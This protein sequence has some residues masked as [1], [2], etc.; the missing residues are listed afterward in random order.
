M[1]NPRDI[2]GKR[3]RRRRRRRYSD[4]NDSQCLKTFRCAVPTAV[5]VSGPWAGLLF[6]GGCLTFR[7][8]AGV[9]LRRICSEYCTCCHTAIEVLDQ[10]CCLTQ[11]KYNDTGSASPSADPITPGAGIMESDERRAAIV[12]SPTVT[13]RCVLDLMGTMNVDDGNW[14]VGYL[15]HRRA[16]CQTRSDQK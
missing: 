10:K 12:F 3:R 4:F 6:W 15:N 1:V 9:S 16:L 2:A 7:Q 13:G 14:T 8:H 11:S 5:L